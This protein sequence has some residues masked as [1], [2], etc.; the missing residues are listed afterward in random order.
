MRESDTIQ[1][2]HGAGGKL[3][4]E[5]I[6]FIT[7]SVKLRRVGTGIGLDE[8]EDA[9]S[10]PLNTADAD[11]EVVITAD[12]HTVFPLKFPGGD[13]GK[14]AVCGTVNDLCMMGGSPVAL[15]SV[16]LIE[17][18]MSAGVVHEIME[19]FNR[20][21]E[22]AG[23]AI[24]AGDTKVMPKGSLQE[25]VIATTGVGKKPKARVIL[26]RNVRPGDKLL[27]TGSIGDH[28]L[29]LMAAREGINLETT[30]ESDVAILAP[31]AEIAWEFPGL[32]M[33]KDPTRGG[34]ASALNDVATKSH[35][36]VWLQE[37]AIPVK[38]QVQAVASVLG[39]DP[40]EVACEGRFIAAVSAGQAEDLVAALRSHPLGADAAIIGEAR[41]E[42]AGKVLMETAVGGTRF[43]DMPLGELI[44]RIC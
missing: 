9:A 29:A 12:G 2:G 15:T 1:L 34:L 20:T 40:L 19:S 8:L 10:I 27:L 23:V 28:G 3:Q 24:I 13:L 32:H 36:S 6:D 44:P 35:V 17:E 22:E 14:L 7:K 11:M 25:M 4:E 42:R 31:L 41:A 5:L 21:A 30:L 16:V 37:D 43:V 18:G 26:N 39:L 38:P 33:M